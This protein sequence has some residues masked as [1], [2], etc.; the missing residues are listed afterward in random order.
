M[1]SHAFGQ[2]D[3]PK[4][5]QGAVQAYERSL[6]FRRRDCV[7]DLQGD[8]HV[9]WAQASLLFKDTL[10]RPMRSPSDGQERFVS[11]TSSTEACALRRASL[12]A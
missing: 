4:P 9:T 5:K 6:I 3:L 7:N 10:T 1:T 11:G 8:H 2:S 12:S